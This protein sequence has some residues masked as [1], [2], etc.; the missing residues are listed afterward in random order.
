MVRYFREI[1]PD[2]VWISFLSLESY[3]ETPP[4]IYLTPRQFDQPSKGFGQIWPKGSNFTHKSDSRKFWA[5]ILIFTPSKVC[6]VYQRKNLFD[7]HV[8]CLVS[9][10]PTFLHT[11][12]LLANKCVLWLDCTLH[13][14]D[15]VTCYNK[16]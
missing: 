6:E 10:L 1:G 9:L 3:L 7:K 15:N 16:L 4:N 2:F 5:K 11:T 8:Q 13:V 14:T 12:P